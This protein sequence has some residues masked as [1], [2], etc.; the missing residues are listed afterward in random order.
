MFV[1]IIQQSLQ[2]KLVVLLFTSAMILLGLHSLRNIPIDAVPDI[3]NNQVQIVTTSPS[4]APQ[5]VEKFI[6]Y[7]LEIAMANLPE[8]EEIRSI[9]R[10]GLSVI[11][12][13]FHDRVPTLDARQYVKEKIDEVRAD[14]PETFGSPELMP[15]TTGLGEIFQYVLK[16]DSAYRDI[17]DVMDL[18]TIQDWIVK[19]QLAGIPGIIEVSSFGGYLK[20]YEVAIDPYS[21]AANN[22]TLS[23]VFRA[24]EE[25]NQN[26][27]GSYIEKGPYATYIRTEG[28]V[29]SL[30]D[31][32][33]IHV[34][35]NQ[36]VPIRIADVA[37]V[38]YGAPPR[39]GAM[40]MDGEGET[41][42]G[43]TLMLKGE[44]SYKVNNAVQ[45]RVDEIQKLLPEGISLYPFLERSGLI[46]RTIA[47]VRNNLLEGGLIVILV[48][49]LL[50]GN[51]RAGLVVASIIPL[52]MLFAISCMYYTGVSANLMSLGAI[53]FGIVVDSAVVIVENLV[54]VLTAGFV[55]KTL[56]QA[57]MDREIANSAANIYKSAAFGVLTTIVVFI[58]IL[59]LSGIEGKMFRPMAQTLT[60]ALVG[61]LILS[62]TYVP[63]ISSLVMSKKVKKET[64]F[65]YR[66]TSKLEAFYGRILDQVLKKWKPVVG[67]A[68]L[69]LVTAI[70]G[71]NRLGAEFIPDLEEGDLAVQVAIQ[72]GSSLTESIATATKVERILKD[73]FPE[74]KHVVSKI[75]TA[76]IPTDPMAMEDMDIMI[77]M[78]EKDEWTSAST[79]EELIDLMKEKLEVVLGVFVEFSQP[80]QLRFNELMT[81]VKTDIAVK[82]YGED[83]DVLFEKANQAATLIEGIPGADDIK[84]EQTDGLP[85]LMLRIDRDALARYGI[86]VNE[87]NQVVRTAFAGTVAGMVYDGQRRF[88][89][90]V[91]LDESARNRTNISELFVN[92]SSGQRI[93]LSELVEQSFEE[94]P[95]QISRDNTQRRINIGVNVR[96]RDVAS[97][98]ADI[99]QRLQTD[100]VLPPGYRIQ[101]GGTFEN[102]QKAKSRLS[103]AVPIALIM[104]FLLLY[105]AFGKVK[106][107]LMIG[108]S[109]PFSAIGGVAALYLRDMPFSISAGIGFIALF[110]VA[111]LNGI[112]L[113]SA[114]NQLR[115]ERGMEV[116]EAV[117]LGSKSRLRPV[118]MTGLVAALG[119]IPM[120]LST[121]AGAEVQKP[122]ATVVIGG[123]V[124]DTILTLLLLPI[125]YLRFPKRPRLN[126]STLGM[127]ALLILPAGLF[128][129]DGW[130]LETA[131]KM[132]AEAHP[133][134]QNARLRELQASEERKR[135]VQMDKFDVSYQYGQ[136]NTRLYDYYIEAN[137]NFGSILQHIKRGAYA[138]DLQDL[139]ESERVLTQRQLNLLVESAWYEWL[140]RKASLQA[141]NKELARLESFLERI[142][143]L[144]ESGEI[145]MLEVQVF[146]ARLASYRNLKEQQNLLY[147]RAT[148]ELRVIT[149]YQGDMNT[150]FD[151][152][153]ILPLPLL[154]SPLHPDILAAEEK[155]VQ[156]EERTKQ[157][158]QAA[159]FPDLT[160]GYF[161]QEIEAVPNFQ[162]VMVGL[163][164]PLWFRPQRAR[165]QQA[166]LQV[167]IARNDFE[168]AKKNR[169]RERDD[170]A[171]EVAAQRSQWENYGVL[172][173]EQ[174]EKIAD[175]A[176]LSYESGEIDFFQLAEGLRTALEL[177]IET[178]EI[179]NRYNQAVIR[180]DFFTIE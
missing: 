155:V 115:D 126:V 17:Y 80:I 138:R 145:S 177:N 172:A 72:P 101:Y 71:F 111:V 81:G 89:L 92:S 160:A 42:G 133:M 66:M 43:I 13:V 86:S 82:I 147:I 170:A 143:L 65:A 136:F 27:G 122:L 52:S 152:L 23:D 144:G 30:E 15:I 98:V 54:A 132:A 56:S 16:V 95:M 47:T 22:L 120:A 10:Y 7:P 153:D 107:A 29:S 150:G 61:T 46:N 11:T 69:L 90:V 109:V 63:V 99:E 131:K 74:V 106:Y 130:S 57:Q 83:L 118:L 20:Q 70:V 179:I 91:R 174:A 164:F 64:G 108:S 175:A 1:Y 3:T 158:E 12:V 127:I 104:I 73:N 178:L 119:F 146:R 173:R 154:S 97:L 159:F 6:T 180:F 166:K 37:E 24:L 44:N 33:K 100:L 121:S 93:L 151:D 25:N 4:L 94:G 176:F 116:R 123:I 114:I 96:N 103:V 59:S 8:V 68:T 149:G 148:N 62:L 84:V 2:N 58:P 129:Q 169:E 50:L 28:L 67:L 162:G 53:D 5:E 105:F 60:F 48:L 125:M 9:S 34:A 113:I 75:G 45:Q 38:R 32:A 140:T 110:G 112:V 31:V 157:I 142:T 156:V 21:L 167:E 134:L 163:Q 41:V 55:G 168:F 79:R 36:G 139:R 117:I 76:E 40:T 35:T 14:I 39:Y 77:V 171:A 137:Q 78:K 128:A 161:N 165:I 26:T 102:L 135:A 88:D 87:V 49:V 85:Q 51:F 18:R 124:S 141:V 19:R